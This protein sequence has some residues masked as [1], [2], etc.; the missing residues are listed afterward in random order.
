MN[1]CKFCKI[2]RRE[3]LADIVYEDDKAIAFH[4]IKKQAPVHILVIPR[5]HIRSIVEIADQDLHLI[6]H[7]FL[8]SNKIADRHDVSEKGFRLVM[9]S[10]LES[11]Q[12]VWHIHI[13][14]LGGRRMGWPPG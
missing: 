13:H 9:N 2:V 6:G 14:L 3:S 10:G 7:L 5:K 8:V 4:D 11:G 1:D 12:S